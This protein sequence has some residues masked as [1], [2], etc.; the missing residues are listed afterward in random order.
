M[1]VNVTNS[2]CATWLRWSCP[3]V[4]YFRTLQERGLLSGEQ[5][6][7]AA[8]ETVQRSRYGNNDYFF[9]Y[10]RRNVAISHA[11]P[12]IR[13]RDMSSATDSQGQPVN[14]LMWEMTP[15]TAGWLPDHRLD[16][17]G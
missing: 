13:G 1:P 2:S 12:R 9:I 15:A 4:D 6:R 8:L 11:D 5:A 17:S 7:R 10:D 14:K 3:Q 16:P